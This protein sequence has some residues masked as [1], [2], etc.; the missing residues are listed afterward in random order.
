MRGYF[1]GEPPDEIYHGYRVVIEDG[2][3]YEFSLADLARQK[4]TSHQESIQ[5]ST[6]QTDSTTVIFS[7]PRES[8]ARRT[9]S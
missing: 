3:I 9:S 8:H 1:T 4:K 6:L 2:L 5:L 7:E